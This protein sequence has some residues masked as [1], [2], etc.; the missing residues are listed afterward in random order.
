M[1][2]FPFGFWFRCVWAR[3][4][5]ANKKLSTNIQLNERHTA[6]RVRV[7]FRMCDHLRRTCGAISNVNTN[8]HTNDKSVWFWSLIAIAS[9][10]LAIR[11]NSMG[12][13]ALNQSFAFDFS[14]FM[15]FFLLPCILNFK[16]FERC[17]WSTFENQWKNSICY[18]F[19]VVY[20]IMRQ[21]NDYYCFDDYSLRSL[22]FS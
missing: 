16:C 18:N 22:V 2:F 4:S 20:T 15:P 12:K 17:F 10:A 21:I 7:H 6:T 13:T 11:I 3:W 1:C 14:I 5:S 19:G 8:Q 9:R